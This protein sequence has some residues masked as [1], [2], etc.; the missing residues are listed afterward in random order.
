MIFCSI[1]NTY[2]KPTSIGYHNQGAT[3][4]ALLYTL[5]LFKLPSLFTFQALLSLD[6][7]GERK[8]QCFYQWVEC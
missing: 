6:T 5:L 4:L 8:K 1:I 2:A 7:L 3:P